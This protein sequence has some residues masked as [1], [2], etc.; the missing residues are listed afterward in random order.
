[1]YVFK[2]TDDRSKLIGTSRIVNVID[3]FPPDYNEQCVLIKGRLINLFGPPQY[4]TLN[5]ENQYSYII[6]ATGE[7]KK[8]F[9]LN[10]Y[11]G[12]SG[13]AI[14]G[15][16]FVDGIESAALAL[17]DYIQTAIPA[18]FCYE[19]YYPDAP[20]KISMGIKCGKVYYIEQ[21]ISDPDEIAYMMEKLH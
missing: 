4:E 6:Q 19:G 1:M 11:E 2:K 15:D 17:I 8:I 5:L 12:S 18:D 20:S 9:Y 3:G 7:D 16:N 10:I 21:E 14:G 13:P